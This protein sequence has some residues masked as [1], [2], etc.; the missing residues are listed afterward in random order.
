[1][2]KE[3]Y[4]N[5]TRADDVSS[6]GDPFGQSPS[7]KKFMFGTKNRSSFYC[8]VGLDQISGLFWKRTLS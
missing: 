1:M 5:I 3:P 8:G 4:Q 2:L 7:G 6:P